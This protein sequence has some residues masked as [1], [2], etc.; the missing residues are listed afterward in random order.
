MTGTDYTFRSI[1]GSR[2]V[3]NKGVRR[4]EEFSGESILSQA[5]ISITNLQISLKAKETSGNSR[6]RVRS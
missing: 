2:R 4:A 3:V 1:K 6:E 5:K